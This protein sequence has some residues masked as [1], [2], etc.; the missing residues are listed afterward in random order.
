MRRRPDFVPIN[1]KKE[2]KD[3]RFDNPSLIFGA[4]C[5]YR[6]YI[7]DRGRPGFIAAIAR[8]WKLIA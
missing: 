6:L 2:D 5:V 1:D 3:N 8:A 7:R 4:P